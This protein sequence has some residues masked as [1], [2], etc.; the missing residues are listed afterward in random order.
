MPYRG[1]KCCEG[2]D[3]ADPPPPPFFVG[4]EQPHRTAVQRDISRQPDVAALQHHQMEREGRNRLYYAVLVWKS[5]S[6]SMTSLHMRVSPVLRLVESV[7][8]WLLISH[9]LAV[10]VRLRLMLGHQIL[11]PSRQH[12]GNIHPDETF[13]S[14]DYN[15]KLMQR[16]QM[17]WI[18]SKERTR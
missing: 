17:L 1:P 5:S 11:R 2:L 18:V 9:G 16:L 15:V 3:I 14:E 13:T 6:V 12:R 8:G 10:S 7:R 4:G